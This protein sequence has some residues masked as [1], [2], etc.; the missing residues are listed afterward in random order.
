MSNRVP[1]SNPHLEINAASLA[2]YGHT[3]LYDA[4]IVWGSES[5]AL[6]IVLCASH[7]AMLY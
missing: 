7:L 5:E 1:T 2:I 4:K 6:P 3:F